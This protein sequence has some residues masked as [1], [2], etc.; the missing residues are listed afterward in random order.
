MN[1]AIPHGKGSISWKLD[2]SQNQASGSA[3]SA[4]SKWREP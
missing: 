4:Q 2:K 3:T 1:G